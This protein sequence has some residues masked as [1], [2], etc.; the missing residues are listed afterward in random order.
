M[1]FEFVIAAKFKDSHTSF[2]FHSNSYVAKFSLLKYFQKKNIF[3][4]KNTVNSILNTM[5]T[6]IDFTFNIEYT[7]EHSV[8]Y[9]TYC[10]FIVLSYSFYRLIVE[11][12]TNDHGRKKRSLPAKIADVTADYYSALNSNDNC[13]VTA[14]FPPTNVRSPFMIGDNLTYSNYF[15]GP[16]Q[17]DYAYNIW[18]G[19]FSTVDG[20][21]RFMHFL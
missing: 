16:L 10:V 8:I 2:R 19:A 18:F 14:Q 12:I 15:N 7:I 3:L 11:R 9:C 4:K 17:P 6:S 5:F 20:V 13:Y 1:K 21:R